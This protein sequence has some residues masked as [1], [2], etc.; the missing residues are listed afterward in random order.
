MI[1]ISVLIPV[2]NTAKFIRRC[3]DS[4]VSQSLKEIEIIVVNDATPDNAMEIVRE[5]AANDSRFVIIDKKKNE[6]PMCAR[7]DGYSIA[8]GEYILFCDS[9]DY[10]LPGSFS[11]L[12]DKIVETNADIVVSGYRYIPVKGQ[13]YEQISKLPFGNNRDAAFESLLRKK[14]PHNLIANIYRRTLFEN[15]TYTCK[16]NCTN[17]E[18]FILF[19][20]IISNI[21]TIEALNTPTYAYCQNKE[22]ATNASLS[23][24]AMKCIIDNRV[25]WYEWLPKAYSNH[26]LI[27]ENMINDLYLKF[28]AGYDRS[29]L[30][31]IITSLG[32]SLTRSRIFSILGPLKG[33][34]MLSF[35]KNIP[36][37]RVLCSNHITRLILTRI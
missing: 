25:N 6:G 3:L 37:C 12:Y 36:G 23:K 30:E 10:Y 32:E 35:L 9:D 19:Y 28:V 22:S 18:D 1:K 27:E 4:I 8:K 14:I 13:G 24:S 29:M 2:Y 31:S 11:M 34:V 26:H 33:L 20:E 15:H 7:K 21:K 16:P 17:G 5:F